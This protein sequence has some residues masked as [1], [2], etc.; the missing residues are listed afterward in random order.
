MHVHVGSIPI[1]LQDNIPPPIVAKIRKEYTSNPEFDP[2]KIKTASTAAEGLCK[3][4]VAME[5]YDRVARVVEPK[6]VKLK[7]SEKKL[8]VAMEVRNRQAQ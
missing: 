4:V 7:E 2:A 5:Q 3:W 1:S 6:K 8:A